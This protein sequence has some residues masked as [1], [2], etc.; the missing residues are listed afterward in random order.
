MSDTVPFAAKKK[1]AVCLL[2]CAGYEPALL[3]EAIEKAAAFASFPDIRGKRILVKPNVL[4][5]SPVDKAVTTHPEFV[6]AVL[7][8]LKARGA[9]KILVGDSPAWQAGSSASKTA[10]IYQAVGR[11]G[12][13]WIDFSPGKP[14]SAPQAKLVKSFAFASVLED[15]D[16]IVNLPKLKTHRLMIYTGAIKNFF[17]LVPGLGKS[18]M[19]LRFPDR[20]RFG[21]MLVDLASSLPP[22]FTFM[23]GIITMEGE[24]PGN[25][26]P[27]KLGSILASSDAA[28]LDWIAAQCIGYEPRKIPYLVDALERGGRDPKSPDIVVGPSSVAQAAAKNFD[29][30]PYDKEVS[31]SASR[32]PAF[33]KVLFRKFTVDKPIFDPGACIGCLACV[34]ICPAHA[35]EAGKDRRGRHRIRIDDEACITCF[36]CHE[37]CPAHAVS[38]GKAPFRMPG[39]RKKS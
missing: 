2:G 21:T 26:T 36:C 24:G 19:H 29:L 1:D 4:N 27:F 8:F 12:A 18:G 9:A 34:K 13:E 17:G 6:A 11:S 14:R 25:G 3:D 32:M 16:L 33:A 37:V 35:L 23:D 15:C 28:A 22:S 30:L 20:L 39:K 38:I 10:G 31:S 5:A 7:R